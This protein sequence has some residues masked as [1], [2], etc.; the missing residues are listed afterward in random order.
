MARK[1]KIMFE[2]IRTEMARKFIT[3]QEMADTLGCTRDTLSNK[4]SGKT[5]INLDEAIILNETYFPEIDIKELFKE[6]RVD[7]ETKSA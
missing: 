1:N 7:K 6:L 5:M 3:I 4:L 2:T